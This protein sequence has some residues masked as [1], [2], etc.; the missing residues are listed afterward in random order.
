MTHVFHSILVLDELDHVA[1]SFQSLVSVFSLPQS[2]SSCLRI[3]GIANTHTLTSSASQFSNH[4]I[5]GVK[6]VHFSPYTPPQLLK[7]LQSRLAPLYENTTDEGVADQIKKLLPS[8]TLTLL[9]KKIAAQSGDVRSLFEVLRGAIDL[10]VSP[11]PRSSNAV[12]LCAL[13]PVVTPSF[14]LSALKAYA[15]ATSITRVA[16]SL[17]T[18]PIAKASWN[19]EI[20]LKVR[21]LGFQARLVLLC[22][23]L[24]SKRLE[25]GLSLS[26]STVPKSPIKRTQS[27]PSPVAPQASIAV[28]VAQLHLYYSGVLGKSE[29]EL[30]MPVSRSELGDLVGI[31]ET[32]GLASLSSSLPVRSASPT[33]SGRRAFGRTASSGSVGART[34]DR[35]QDV[36]LAESVRCAEVFRGLGITGEAK[37]DVRTD[38]REEEMRRIWEREKA[39]LNKDIKA[40]ASVSSSPK[41]EDLFEGATED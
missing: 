2:N 31:L 14:I 18:G 24:A 16:L 8:P 6:T 22:L 29:N 20:I 36:R 3:V 26:S 30:F 19:N 21:N 1:A 4:G 38:V 27:V 12:S 25:A 10:A 40:N 5:D 37:N 35:G 39:A 13:S 15:P 11:P 17:P 28:D 7:I 9:T 23:M 41:L 34:Q 33:K 32:V